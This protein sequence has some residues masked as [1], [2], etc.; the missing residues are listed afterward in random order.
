M[1]QQTQLPETR[2]EQWFLRLEYS[3]DL[4][5][6]SMSGVSS[7][8][9]QLKLCSG[10]YT[11]RCLCPWLES[12]RI[13]GLRCIQL[14]HRYGIECKVRGRDLKN[15]SSASSERQWTTLC[16]TFVAVPGLILT[17]QQC[18]KTMQ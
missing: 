12:E 1:L 17:E 2:L 6:N 13:D 18:R 7:Y 3:N 15:Q 8:A 16:E 9:L 10:F 14:E 5:V 4:N 11:K